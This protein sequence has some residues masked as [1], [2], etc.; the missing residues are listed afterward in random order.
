[1]R[2]FSLFSSER[3]RS[4]VSLYHLR[5]F[6]FSVYVAVDFF[7]AVY[8]NKIYHF[9]MKEPC[10]KRRHSVL[11]YKIGHIHEKENEQIVNII[12]KNKS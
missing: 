8:N 1:M 4:L 5:I 10:C 12:Q 11:S 3:L 2:F 9:L 6:V 7:Y